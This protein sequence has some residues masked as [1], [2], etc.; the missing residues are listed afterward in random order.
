M[1]S[2]WN[3]LNFQ[4][5]TF[6]TFLKIWAGVEAIVSN[7]LLGSQLETCPAASPISSMLL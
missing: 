1:V 4:K 7:G 6:V 5:E 2:I 3:S